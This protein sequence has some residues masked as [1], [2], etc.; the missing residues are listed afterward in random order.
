MDMK[1]QEPTWLFHSSARQSSWPSPSGWADGPAKGGE[2]MLRLC[3]QMGCVSAPEPGQR[4]SNLGE[5]DRSLVPIRWRCGRG[6]VDFMSIPAKHKAISS[7]L[8]FQPFK[9]AETV[10]V[11]R[12]HLETAAPDSLHRPVPRRPGSAP[13]LMF[14]NSE[15]VHR[16]RP[17]L[18]KTASSNKK[19]LGNGR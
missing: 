14:T 5:E 16:P 18:F 7:F 19:R 2:Y 1:L 9:G 4:Q 15:S 10:F 11:A 12:G 6:H 3:L 13:P 8:L 17:V